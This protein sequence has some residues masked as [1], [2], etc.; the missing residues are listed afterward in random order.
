MA[1]ETEVVH[2]W[3]HAKGC[4]EVCPCCGARCQNHTECGVNGHQSKYHRP[5]GFAYNREQNDKDLSQD[6]RFVKKRIDGQEEAK[7][8]GSEDGK[9][10]LRLEHCLSK[11]VRGKREEEK[12]VNNGE[13][14][15]DFDLT[16]EMIG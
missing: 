3:D 13:D 14:S 9:A 10:D 11:N 15:N 8:E 6:F 5:W 4:P 12:S 16:K 2:T 1:C 7:G